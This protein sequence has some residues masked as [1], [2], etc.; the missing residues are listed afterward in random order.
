MSKPIRVFYSTLGNRFYATR[1]YRIEGATATITGEKFDVT[2]DI[3]RAIHQHDLEFTKTNVCSRCGQELCDC[4][5][6]DA[7][8]M[9]N[10]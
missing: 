9:K 8:A 4:E 1:H 3:A 7:P 6:L 10:C 5:P 2:D